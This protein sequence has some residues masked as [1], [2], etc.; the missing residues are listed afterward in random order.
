MTFWQSANDEGQNFSRLFL[1]LLNITRLFSSCSIWGQ[2]EGGGCFRVFFLGLLHQVTRF[3]S[4]YSR[5]GQGEG[6]GCGGCCSSAGRWLLDRRERELV[7]MLKRSTHGNPKKHSKNWSFLE[8][9]KYFFLS[10]SIYFLPQLLRD[11]MCFQWGVRY[12]WRRNCAFFT[13]LCAFFYTET[14]FFFAFLSDLNLP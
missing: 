10:F 9:K 2:G 6:G 5:R 3:S 8:K 13:Q 1:F 11:S 14:G 4:S 12:L 7:K